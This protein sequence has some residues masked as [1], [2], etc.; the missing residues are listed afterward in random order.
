MASHYF[1]GGFPLLP[2]WF[3]VTSPMAS[4]YFLPVASHCFLSGFP[5]LPPSC[6]P[7]LPPTGFP[8][9]PRWLPITSPVVSRYFP[10]VFPLLPPSCFPLLPPTGFPSLPRWLPITSPVVSHYFSNGFPLLPK[11]R[12]FT[13]TS[14]WHP[15]TSLVPISSSE[16]SFFNL[17]VPP[18]Q[19]PSPYFPFLI[20]WLPLL[21]HVAS[22]FF[23]GGFLFLRP[24]ASPFHGFPVLMTNCILLS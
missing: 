21:I 17:F 12:G 15:I 22:H 4:H 11:P 1:L 19:I 23:P 9:L 20:P 6:F 2:W 13:I 14:P 16:A 10:N 7:L 18:F 3:P 8:S 5:L 24:V